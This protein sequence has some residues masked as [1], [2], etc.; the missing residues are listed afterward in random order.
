MVQEVQ[1][2]GVQQSVALMAR[3]RY[4]QAAM[5]QCI[6][7]ETL[8]CGAFF[9]HRWQQRHCDMAIRE[10][11]RHELRSVHCLHR[12][13]ANSLSIP[14]SFLGNVNRAEGLFNGLCTSRVFMSTR[15]RQVA[16]YRAS[17]PLV[18]FETMQGC[19]LTVP[20]IM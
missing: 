5:R 17:C 11:Q 2:R 9:S 1:A 14:E 4:Q 3:M 13:R 19:F 12:R 10:S 6:M 16:G 18:I 20:S 15:I 8:T 7:V